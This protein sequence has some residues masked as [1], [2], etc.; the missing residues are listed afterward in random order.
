M[1]P[2]TQNKLTS[3]IENAK[4]MGVS[5]IFK[6]SK[7]Y[8]YIW[9]GCLAEEQ[10]IMFLTKKRKELIFIKSAKKYIL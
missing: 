6:L 3:T 9:A 4:E 10:V 2:I 1:K 5:G 7:R 8:H